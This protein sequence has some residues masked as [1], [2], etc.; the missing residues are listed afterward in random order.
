M[1]V[2]FLKTKDQALSFFKKIKLRA[3]T[4]HGGKLKSLRTDRQESLIPICSMYSNLVW[5][6]TLYHYNL[7]SPVEWS[8]GKKK[9]NCC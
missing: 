9:S 5:H 8:S 6:Q 2:E 3:E 4:D 1:W 7:F